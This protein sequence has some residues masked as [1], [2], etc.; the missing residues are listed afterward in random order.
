MP[1]IIEIIEKRWWWW[2]GIHFKIPFKG[3]I[4]LVLSEK[5]SVTYKPESKADSMIRDIIYQFRARDDAQKV[6][7]DVGMSSCLLCFL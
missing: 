2:W 5:N 6:I 4:F 1:H 7:Q 3:K